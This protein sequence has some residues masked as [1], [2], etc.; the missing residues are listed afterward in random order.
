[1][2]VPR[3]RKGEKKGAYIRIPLV[4]IWV[5]RIEARIAVGAGALRGIL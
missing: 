1:M 2:S 5:I 4:G 3:A